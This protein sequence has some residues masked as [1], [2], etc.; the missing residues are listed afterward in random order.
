MAAAA[1]PATDADGQG[2][3]GAAVEK[4]IGQCLP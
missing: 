4:V 2:A 1:V 3:D